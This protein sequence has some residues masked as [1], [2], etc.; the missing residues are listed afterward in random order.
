[1]AD[2]TNLLKPGGAWITGGPG[3]V[4]IDAVTG[5]I[6][7]TTDGTGLVYCRRG[8]PTEVNKSYQLTWSNDTAQVMFRQ[9]GSAE[10][11]AD[12]RGANVSANGDNKIEFTAISTTTWISFQRTTAATVIVSVPILQE[13]PASAKS[14]RRLNG[15][16]QY[17]SLDV[18][19]AGLRMSNATWFIGGFV[20]FTYMP[21]VGVYLMDFGR[22]DPASPAGG[23]NRI[24]LLWDPDAKKLAASTAETTGT[25]YREN[26]IISTLEVDTWYYVGVTA[27]ANAD[28]LVRLGTQKGAS[29]IGTTLPPVSVTEI[30]RFLQLGARVATARTNFSPVRYSNWI[31]SS[32]WIPSDSQINALAA[33]TAPADVSGLT[34]PA[35]T[36]IYHW[37]MT[38]ETGNEASLITTTAPL[39]SNSTYGSIITVPGPSISGAAATVTTPL[40]IIIT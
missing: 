5:Q 4:S 21:T 31:W 1:M 18:Q 16:T 28:V 24:R 20:A 3:T 22:L 7:M 9:I 27:L 17:F 23:A 35:G 32:G 2:F 37:P 12:I 6:T 19:T 25:N 30:C 13:I 36:N 29:Y 38:V 8:V 10:G 15:K 11:L 26:Y 33:G 40:D 34:A 39:V 14:A